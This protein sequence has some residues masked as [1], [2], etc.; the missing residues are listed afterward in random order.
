VSEGATA[1][2]T[3]EIAQTGR[4]LVRLVRYDPAWPDGFDLSSIG[5]FRSFFAPLLALPFTLVV[6]ALAVSDGGAK[7]FTTGVLVAAGLAHL[8]GAVAF[9][10][11]VALFARPFG[12][13]GGYA[14]FVILVNWASLFLNVAACAAAALTPFGKTGLGLFG[15]FWIL[16]FLT[17]FYVI[18][19][20]ARETL[21]ADYAP[22]VLMV[23]LSVAVGAA[24]DQ[25]GGLLARLLT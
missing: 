18:W 19:R 10:V 21:S 20:A 2:L 3:R 23:V 25:V 11:L 22:A 5:F 1:A 15:F 4:G 13:T 8:F 7:P 16:L 6:A 9:P 14:A 17:Q 24:S 12:L